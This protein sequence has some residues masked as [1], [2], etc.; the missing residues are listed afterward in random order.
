MKKIGVI[1]MI[2]SLVFSAFV[3]CSVPEKDSS[4]SSSGSEGTSEALSDTAIESDG[5]NATDSEVK[6]IYYTIQFDTDG[7]TSMDS[8]SVLS[9][10]KISPP[11][12]PTK[13]TQDCEYVFI[14]W[15]YNGKQWDFENGVVTEDMT[16]VAHWKEEN[17]YSEP[18]LP[19]D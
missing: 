9:G 17:K 14:G 10:E 19:K 18:F 16:L 12:T 6:E 1:A 2:C 13:I 3:A 15:F 5:E 4:K 11:V 8:V 7:G